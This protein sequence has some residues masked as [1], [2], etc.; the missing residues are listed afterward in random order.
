MA[1]IDNFTPSAAKVIQL[2]AQ[3]FRS[4]P[5]AD[6]VAWGSYELGQ[7]GATPASLANFLFNYPVPQSPFTGYANIASN[8]SFASLLVETL[9]FGTGATADVRASWVAAIQPLMPNYASRGDFALDI[10]RMVNEYSGTDAD[11]L[12]V[13]AALASRVDK[14]AGFALSPAGAVYDG[15]GFGQLLAPLQPAPDPTYALT[16]S[17]AQVNEGNGISFELQTTG[18]AAGSSLPYTISGVSTADVA[19]GVLAGSLTLDANGR[20]LLTLALVADASTE[21]PETL[22]LTVGNNL[23]SKSVTV[24]DT[25]LTPPPAST[26]ALSAS[27]SSV[28]EGGAVD[29]TLNTTQLSAGSTVA[30]T[31][32][33]ISSADIGGAPLSGFFTL[34]AQG[35]GVVQIPLTADALTEGAETLRLVLSGGVG[36]IEVV[37]NDTSLTPPPVGT[38][39]LVLIADNMNNSN[40]HPPGSPAE[41]EIPL[42]TYLTYDLL[43]QAGTDDV[44]MSVAALKASGAVA[45]APLVLTNQSADRGNLP[46]LSNQSLYTFD[47]GAQTDRVD[48]S[49]ETGKIVLLV[50]NEAAVGTQ[51]VLVNDNGVDDAFGGA[52][53]RMDTLKNVEEVVAAAGAGVIDLTN[54]GQDW[55]IQFSRNFNTATDVDASLDRASHR[56]ELSDLNS[57]QP[58]ARSLFEYRD[59]GLSGSITQANALW[60]VVQGSDRNETLVLS[61]AQSPE[62][63]SSILRGGTNTVKFNELTRSIVVD[64]AMSAWVPSSNLADDTNSSGRTLATVTPTTGDGVT[65]LSGNTHVLSS[66]TPDNGVAAGQLKLVGS[67]DAEDAISFNSSPAPKIFTLG[68]SLSGQDGASVRLAGGPETSALEFSGFEFLRDNG[69]SDDVY[70]I[71]NIFRATQGSP[72]LTDGA[73][74]DH[75]TVRL[76]NEALGSAAVGGAISAVN[77]ATLN[78]ASPGF[79]VDFDVLDLSALSA[80]GLQAMGTAGSDDE[81]VLGRLASVSAVT[82]FEAVVLTRSSTDKGTALV[83]DLD[84]GALKA[85]STT[86]FSYAGSVLSLGGLVFGS[87][88]QASTVAPMDT[89]MS[90]TVVDSTVGPG[91]TVWGG[92]AADLIVGGS[93]DD[94]LRGGGGND[95][96]DGGLPGGTGSFAETWAFTLSGTPDAV[97]A[98]GKRIT[99]AMTIDGTAL[100]LTEAAVADT[101][102][103]DGNGAV[104]DGASA[105]TIGVAMAALINANLAAINAGPGNGTLTGAS[106][107]SA[108]DT[109][110]LSFLAGFNTNDVVT[111]VLNS[112]AD[113]DGGNFALSAGVNVNG[114]NGGM[115][116][117]V[118][119]ASAAANGRDTLL[120]FTVGSDKLDFSAFAGAAIAAASPALNGATGGTLAGVATTAEFIF[121]KAQAL[122]SSADFATS[123]AAGKFVLADGARCVVFVTADPTG[124]RGDAANTAVH[125]YFVENGAAA[126]LDDL[127]VVLVGTLTGP[128]EPTLG[129]LFTA[130][131]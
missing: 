99:I 121:N 46:Q 66:H 85:G 122:L 62:A 31:L 118:F 17:S 52:T 89:G 3:L 81:L 70:A 43:N 111:F 125:I 24:N 110:L 63:R 16:A 91:A 103:G 10:V 120:N 88:G 54:S 87:A 76:A 11:L 119:E 83:F 116:R 64:V 71:D 93:G 14:A 72:R 21:G 41:G 82:L 12:A 60:G 30:Y 97:A 61:S 56:V 108:S 34:D 45:G 13:K 18:L 47:L 131:T 55:L 74:N 104:L 129:D 29:I 130:S 32:Q 94:L 117:F 96:L 127:S 51:Y 115:D 84:A 57:G 68:Q 58:Y 50:T 44:R 75:D 80:S 42:N 36:Q 4:A 6:L 128:V 92:A 98:A 67:Q 100:T 86:L 65:P 48:Y 59:A 9:S 39:D 109:V 106:Y 107:D 5:T 15:K 113:P 25:S 49:A 8:S 95:T 112:G 69:A 105:D 90:I 126:G 20:A 102:Y 73:G 19:G 79:G 1:A 7:P 124:A 27:L 28:N 37:V 123:A 78:G 35:R 22:V 77:L 26:Y 101:S 2:F 40:A 33:G 23:V 53:D 114:G 38:P